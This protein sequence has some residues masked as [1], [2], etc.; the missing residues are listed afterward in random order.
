MPLRLP[1]L[2]I[3]ITGT[4]YGYRREDGV[5]V[6]PIGCLKDQRFSLYSHSFPLCKKK[7]FCQ[8]MCRKNISYTQFLNIAVRSTEPEEEKALEHLNHLCAGVQWFLRKHRGIV[9]KRLNQYLSWYEILYN[10]N[11]TLEEF[12][13]LVFSQYLKNTDNNT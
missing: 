4:E 6:I 8:N 1:D 3:V 12:E 10:E 13:K 9:K 5:F 2:K 11:P 7:I